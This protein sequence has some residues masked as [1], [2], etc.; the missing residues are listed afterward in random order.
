VVRVFRL[1]VDRRAEMTSFSLFFGGEFSMTRGRRGFTLI[2][3]LVVIAIIAVLIS[4]L[5]PAVQSAREAARKAQC[6]NNLKQL[7]LAVHNYISSNDMLPPVTVDDPQNGSPH[8]NYSFHARLLPF[9]EQQVMYNAMN[10]NLAG[11]WSDGT[12]QPVNGP[13]VTDNAA[14]GSNTYSQATVI[15][16]QMNAFLCPSD[17]LPGGSGTFLFTIG[18]SR[19]VASSN[20]PCNIGLNRRISNNNSWVPNGPAYT[21]TNW[22]GAVNRPVSLRMFSDGT[23][24]TVLMSEWVK[25]SATSPGKDGLGEVYNLPSSGNQSNSFPTDYQFA[26]ACQQTAI[27]PANQNWHWKGEWWIYGGTQVYS[28][29]IPPNR[30]AC[31]YS[32][33]AQDSRGTITLAN[34]SS[35]H[36]GGVT[37]LM[38][39]G[40][41]RFIKSSVNYVAWYG[42]STPNNGEVV[43]ADQY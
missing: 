18:G 40:S 8:Q 12:A 30:T 24:N 16:T 3:L 20:Y 41:V 13:G 11:R 15:V 9:I 35:L 14:G 26:Q 34:A 36:P 29:T 10:T 19:L 2:E 7:G 1:V 21:A 5:L 42:I 33:Q 6:T 25:A 17:V 23:S 32:D 28:H 31:A 22:D 27:G 38:A 39:D 43:S 4:L 37:C